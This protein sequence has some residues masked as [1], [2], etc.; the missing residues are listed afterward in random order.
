VEKFNQKNGVFPTKIRCTGAEEK[1]ALI[2]IFNFDGQFLTLENANK[3][4]V[5]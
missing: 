3:D 1:L 5:I 4:K 2:S